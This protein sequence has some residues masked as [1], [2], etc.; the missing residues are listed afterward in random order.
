[1]AFELSFFRKAIDFVDENDRRFI[2]R[3]LP[4]K[5]ANSL[6]AYAYEN[7][8][9]ITSMCAEEICLGFAGNRFG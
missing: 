7:F 8:V 9:E 4:E 5:V 1:V 3:R 2:F 6:C